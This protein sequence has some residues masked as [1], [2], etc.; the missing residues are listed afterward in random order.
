MTERRKRR[1]EKIAKILFGAVIVYE[2]F[3]TQMLVYAKNLEPTGKTI[4]VG[5]NGIEG[6]LAYDEEGNVAGYE[7]DYL[8]TVSTIT[9]WNFQYVDIDHYYD[10][11]EKLENKE[12][13]LIGHCQ[14]TQEQMENFDYSSY[15][16]G[17]EYTTF[18][19]LKNNMA[20]EF[21]DFE[22][23]K[24][25]TVALAKNDPMT[26]YFKEYMKENDFS[27]KTE[28]YDTSEEAL[29]ALDDGKVEAAVIS[30][31]MCGDKYKIL[32]R[33]S[34][35]PFY[36]MTWKGNEELLT[37]LNAAMQNIK[38]TYP[39]LENDLLEIYY[40][41]YNYQFFSAEE[42]EFIASQ[43]V[44][45]VGYIQ[46]RSPLSSMNEETGELEGISRAIFDEIEEICGLQFEYVPLDMRGIDNSYIIEN[47]IDFVT[48]VEL[49]SA[50]RNTD[51]MLMSN[52]Y[53]SSRKVFVGKEG[54]SFSKENSYKIALST[55]SMTLPKVI[56]SRY[57][58]FEI[59]EYD[60]IEECFE[61]VKS[62]E[63]DLLLQN[64]YV[65]EKWLNCPRYEEMSMIP[66]EGMED[67]LC[68]AAVLFEEKN[69]SDEVQLINIINKAIS[70][71]TQDQMDEII[72]SETME[73]KYEYT[74]GDFCYRYRWV[75]GVGT[76][77]LCML[78]IGAFYIW[79][80]KEKENAMR[81]K[82]EH[83]VYLQQKRY[84]LIIDRS[85]DLIYELSLKEESWISSQRIKEKFGWEVPKT[86]KDFSTEK[87]MEAL[88]I[89]PDDEE[90]VRQTYERMLKE[91]SQGEAVLR[92]KTHTGECLWCKV[93]CMPFLDEQQELAS[94]VGT[95]E[96]VDCE[97]KE[98]EKLEIQS[99]TDGLTGLM[100]KK[101]FIEETKKYLE[102]H[103]SASTGLIFVDLDHFKDVND[104]LGHAMGDYAIQK[105][106]QKLQV[107]FANYDLVSRFGGDEFCIFVKDIPKLTLHDKLGWA[108]DKLKENFEN[109]TDYV[110]VTASIGAVY[111]HRNDAEYEELFNL[112][113]EAVY[114]AKRKGRNRYILKEEK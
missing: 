24:G 64:Q 41:V 101:T 6:F 83:R 1:R 19:T 91:K 37:E 61:A 22:S 63:A 25:M 75:L 68:F 21:E 5:I 113:D 72:I 17:T 73:H 74:F 62:G 36:F 50:N 10:G 11:L 78:L 57:P 20:Y 52:P 109:E 14:I 100:N 107:I 43:D 96:D 114:E 95:I 26:D 2:C 89:H 112:A 108:V 31:M 23:F 34:P 111:C 27:V 35:T 29:E 65:V 66:A 16:Y 38:N 77:F 53:F 54:L 59:L 88:H 4:R 30:L 9:G 102:E 98:K 93:I 56:A 106:A 8:R 40:P 67:D 87:I 3:A 99:R 33:F 47:D 7:Q 82:E 105:S 13:D 104:T 84:Q 12:I 58:N 55:V 85:D 80:L 92:I 71:I 70:Q 48:G 42:R 97:I 46:G 103:S 86:I 45:R 15:S 49:N 44:L 69:V 18:V 51:D 60:T 39:S 28:Y 79:K 110:Q 94:I 90:I 81:R 76:S 32:A